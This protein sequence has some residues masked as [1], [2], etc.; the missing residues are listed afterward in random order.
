MRI[1]ACAVFAALVAVAAAQPLPAVDLF[2][3]GSPVA[4][5]NYRIP[6]LTATARGT[7][8]AVAEARSQASDCAY[9]YLV[10]RRSTDGGKT[11]SPST[12][13][14]GMNATAFTAGN[15]QIVFDALR[16]VTVLQFSIGSNP[17]ACNP[18]LYSMQLDDGGS[19]G[20]AWGNLRNFTAALGSFGGATPGP[21]AAVQ[22]TKTHP[23]RLLFA[24]HDGAYVRDT[25]YYSDDGGLTYT[26]SATVIAGMDEPSITELSNGSVL[27]NM[28]NANGCYCQALSVSNDG[29]ETWG[30][31]VYYDKTLISPICEGS[32]VN[33]GGVIY[34]S[35][36]A[37]QSARANL[38]VRR[39]TTDGD[40]WGTST[41][42][43]QPGVLFGGYSC[44]AP[45]YS[46]SVGG[47]AY[48]G[49]LFERTNAQGQDVISFANFPL[50]F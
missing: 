11:W 21:G 19:D 34:F 8:I 23:G 44:M 6:A 45:G 42:L 46:V 50:D 36:P 17:S 13:I 47:V 3:A 16:N 40:T 24:V 7:L 14:Y 22:L 35:N 38:T 33:V 18:T 37:S 1:P 26:L 29:G 12:E 30:L 27:L 2:I 9:K 32:T 28:R 43:V 15:P 5:N 10:A 41:Y 4:I 48:G 49:I 20:L 39:S 25:V 31:P